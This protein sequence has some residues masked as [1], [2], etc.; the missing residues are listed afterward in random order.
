MKLG[1][2]IIVAL[3]LSLISC[4]RE[5]LNNGSASEGEETFVQLSLLTLKSDDSWSVATRSSGMTTTQEQKITTLDILAFNAS[6][7][8]VSRNQLTNP[9][10][11]S[12]ISINTK[13]GSGMSIYAIANSTAQASGNT[14]PYDMLRHVVSL[15]DLQNMKIYNVA[16][17]IVAN[18]SLV[19]HGAA[20]GIT[21]NANPANNNISIPL[22]YAAAKI[23]VNIVTSLPA[24]ESFELTDWYIQSY[25]VFSYL[26]PRAGDAV[27]TVSDFANSSPVASTWEDKSDILLSDGVTTKAGKTTVFYSYE[28]R[29][30]TIT[31]TDQTKKTGL[32]P[33]N[34]TAIVFRGYYKTATAV[35]AV[36]ATVML[37]SNS[38][39]DYNVARSNQYTYT[40]EIKGLNNINVDTRYKSGSAGFTTELL[41]PTL[42]AHYDWRPL[43]LGSWQGTA[44]IAILDAGGNPATTGFWLKLSA[45]DI[46]HFVNQAGTYVRPT[47]TPST[48]MVYSISNIAFTNPAAI[49]Y[50]NYYL[51][52]DEYLV[53]GGLRT[54][55]V[56]ITNTLVALPSTQSITL[57]VTQKGAQSM[58]TVGLRAI[59]STD[60]TTITTTNYNLLVELQEE[61]AMYI[62][63]GNTATENTQ[64]MQWGFQTILLAGALTPY[65]Q[66]AGLANTT[67]AVISSGTTLRVPY[68]RI[69]NTAITEATQD[70][71]FNTYAARYCYEKNRDL[72]GNGSISDTEIKW[73]LP[74][75]DELM[76]IYVGLNSLSQIATE[77][78]NPALYSTSTETAAATSTAVN[79][80]TGAPNTSV[81]KNT[82]YRIRCVRAN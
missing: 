68:G 13:T 48:D 45:K 58:G 65:S 57:N 3:L 71:I 44:S 42:D 1:K 76:L 59:N 33:A 43:R 14:P 7:R 55:Q 81:N 39:G 78:I 24:G 20:T 34:A 62:T 31:N 15:G 26:I 40:I 5:D 74:S 51:Y 79:F 52:A 22:S 72:D 37:G 53:D 9:T 17:D 41:N 27:A 80:A 32:A 28:N 54:A 11:A 36:V 16:S 49:T 12:P 18:N 64:T 63:P 50:A 70:P 61:A 56:K 75:N 25:P 67:T 21:I 35:N 30:G 47:Y 82:P 60:K 8:L 73:Y 29:R 19:M 77:V 10:I 23:R 2:Y 69:G 4:R 6:G 46:V 66:R 38:T